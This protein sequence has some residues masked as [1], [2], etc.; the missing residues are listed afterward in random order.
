MAFSKNHSQD[1][2]KPKIAEQNQQKQLKTLK[3]IE[4]Q[5]KTNKNQ[6]Q[7]K[8]GC[9][10]TKKLKKQIILNYRIACSQPQC[11]RV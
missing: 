8:K 1:S 9:D 2:E 3:V 10:Q 11:P 5:I 7:T 4:K 6:S